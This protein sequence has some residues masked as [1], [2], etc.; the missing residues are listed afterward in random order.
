MNEKN[1]AIIAEIQG[2]TN[3]LKSDNDKADLKHAM[4]AIDE[5]FKNSIVGKIAADTPN[6]V[7]DHVNN[8]VGVSH[9]G[10]VK[11]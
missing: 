1:K 3:D 7:Y 10:K 8:R 9:K 11:W 4:R 2:A 6:V 5:K